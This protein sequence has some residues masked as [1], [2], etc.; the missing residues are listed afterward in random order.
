M[1]GD[2]SSHTTCCTKLRSTP[3]FVAPLRIRAKRRLPAA[4]ATLTHYVMAKFTITEWFMSSSLI[5]LFFLY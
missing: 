5:P 3:A 1:L 4:T 2:G